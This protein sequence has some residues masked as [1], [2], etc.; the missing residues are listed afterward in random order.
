MA[1]NVKNVI[2]DIE[3]YYYQQNVLNLP[4]FNSIFE[5]RK[6]TYGSWKMYHQ[7]LVHQGVLS[8]SHPESIN[9]ETAPTG[10]ETATLSKD[11]QF[12]FNHI[13]RD[14]VDNANNVHFVVGAAPLGLGSLS[15]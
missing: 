1:T 3:S 11:Q 10:H 4:V 14:I 2:A 5:A 13:T 9:T 15:Y 7:Y 8:R 6:Q 12:H